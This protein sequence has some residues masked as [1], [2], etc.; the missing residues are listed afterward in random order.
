MIESNT[1]KIYKVSS[2]DVGTF[3]GNESKPVVI[4]CAGPEYTLYNVSVNCTRGLARPESE[5]AIVYEDCN[6]VDYLDPSLSLW[7]PAP[8]QTEALNAPTQIKR[9][10]SHLF[11]YCS[12]EKITCGVHRPQY[13]PVKVMKIS[14]KQQFSVTNYNHRTQT[15]TLNATTFIPSVND[16]HVNASLTDGL[17]D[18]YLDSV[19]RAKEHSKKALSLMDGMSGK[20]DLDATLIFGT[21][22]VCALVIMC[23]ICCMGAHSRDGN[24][25]SLC[26]NSLPAQDTIRQPPT[27]SVSS[28]LV[29]TGVT[30]VLE[31]GRQCGLNEAPPM[32]SH[33]RNYYSGVRR[34]ME[35]VRVSTAPG[36][37]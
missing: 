11:V 7:V 25:I 15:V 26:V 32:L 19:R 37:V 8:N 35:T 23:G 36:G 31:A 2:F 20:T 28:P 10:R 14:A 16:T 13:C 1:T 22:L 34:E 3:P 24:K 12:T 5:T 21:I 17:Y 27:I 4:R 33:Q 29:T 6:D 18:Y 9:S 30:R